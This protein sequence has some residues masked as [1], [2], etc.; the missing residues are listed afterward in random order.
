MSTS[1]AGCTWGCIG[2]APRVPAEVRQAGTYKVWNGEIGSYRRSKRLPDPGPPLAPGLPAHAQIGNKDKDNTAAA[3][4]LCR[5]KA[6]H[7]RQVLKHSTRI[8]KLRCLMKRELHWHQACLLKDNT[9]AGVPAPIEAF[10]QYS[11]QWSCRHLL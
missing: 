11:P 3:G 1:G 5:R 8:V 2:T 7:K 10:A 9:A 4:M 6:F